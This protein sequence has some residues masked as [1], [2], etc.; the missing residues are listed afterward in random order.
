MTSLKFGGF[1][2]E[3]AELAE[4]LSFFFSNSGFDEWD[5]IVENKGRAKIYLNY[6]S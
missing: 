1:G 5:I 2:S 3:L 4:T 6:K